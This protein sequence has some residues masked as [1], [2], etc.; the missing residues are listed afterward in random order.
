MLIL[1]RVGVIWKEILPSYWMKIICYYTDQRNSRVS[2]QICI[3]F[4]H[5]MPEN[6]I[7]L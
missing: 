6:F 4:H 2:I 7:E 1:T 3:V 5:R